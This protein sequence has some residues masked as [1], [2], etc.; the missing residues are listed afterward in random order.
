MKTFLIAIVAMC[1][2]LGCAT[3]KKEAV[4]IDG[5]PYILPVPPAAPDNPHHSGPAA[6]NP[7]NS[8]PAP[9]LTVPTTGGDN[10]GAGGNSNTGS[11]GNNNNNNNGS[12]S[13]KDH[14]DKSK[15]HDNGQQR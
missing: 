4:L 7:T 6:T 9:T 3:V 11:S 8:D 1:V 14:P 13:N 10:N 12:G 2:V 5:I 15:N